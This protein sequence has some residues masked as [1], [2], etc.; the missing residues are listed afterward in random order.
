MT[1]K[2]ITDKDF[3]EAYNKCGSISQ[4]AR[5]FNVCFATAE[6][7]IKKSGITEMQNNYNYS[8]LDKDKILEIA[9]LLRDG[10]SPTEI[11]KKFEISR[12]RVYQLAD[13]LVFKD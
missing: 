6:R 1:K 5:D 11:A 2:K 4:V 13:R 9:R 10:E 8:K 3:V 12:R 7:K